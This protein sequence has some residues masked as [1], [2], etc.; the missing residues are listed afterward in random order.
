MGSEETE[1]STDPAGDLSEPDDGAPARPLRPLHFAYAALSLLPAFLV[2]CADVH[3]ALSVPLV[4]L[5]CS[6]GAFFVLRGLGSLEP[7][8]TSDGGPTLRAL[9]PRLIEL[10][11]STVALVAA[12][13]LAVAG[14]LPWPIVSA[15]L[16]V[17]GGTFWIVIAAF[18]VLDG[19]GVTSR[20]PLLERHGFWLFAA[21]VLVYLPLLGSFSLSDPW[22][23]HY[24][25]V[26]REM[27]SRDDWISLW[28]A[29]DGWFWSKPVLDFWLQGISFHLLAPW[30]E[31]LATVR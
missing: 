19:L 26:A 6:I 4:A 17:T 18:R 15:A 23:T 3:F 10:A 8:P 24:G 28:W 27:L 7:T 14:V 13:R 31:W 20:R 30:Q 16:L 11:G 12:L 9:A 21:N 5:S 29:Q 1:T 2:M 22:E 25:E